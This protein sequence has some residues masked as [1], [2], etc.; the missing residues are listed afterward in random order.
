MY[1][2]HTHLEAVRF[3][4]SVRLYSEE[5]KIVQY[6]YKLWACVTELFLDLIPKWLEEEGGGSNN[7][8]VQSLSQI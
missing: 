6:R 7:I 3:Q 2:V 1:I 4:G 8:N 5:E